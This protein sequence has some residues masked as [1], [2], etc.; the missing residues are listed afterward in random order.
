[1]LALKE[2]RSEVYRP[3][4]P[5]KK[6]PRRKR[7]TIAAG[8]AFDDGLLFCV[9]TKIATDIKTNGSKLLFYTHGEGKCA[10]A[11]AISSADLNFP[12]SAV[13]S[14]REAVSKIDFASANIESVR[15]AIQSA[16]AKF[17]REHIFP[18][19][20]RSSGAVYLELLIGIWLKGETRLFV[21]HETLLNEIEDYE[22]I[23]SGAYLAK[24][25]IRQYGYGNAESRTLS[26]AGIISSIAVNAAIDYDEG[27]GGEAD[28][29]ILNNSGQVEETC[30]AVLY[31]GGQLAEGLQREYWKLL[32]DLAQ[33]GADTKLVIENYSDR[34]RKLAA[35]AEQISASIPKGLR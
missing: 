35:H 16:L 11:F 8:F 15:K 3:Q 32:H 31:P 10:T 25:L 24:Y 12:R 18:H 19:P 9:D 4:P 2:R 29:L 5:R 34:I 14:C 22:C 30:R 28:M 17:Y 1:M 33:A 20:D 6:R 27:C 13:E 23:G 21:S 7:M 26:D